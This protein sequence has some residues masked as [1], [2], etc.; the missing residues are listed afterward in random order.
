VAAD[1][2]HV[3][4]VRTVHYERW[5]MEQGLCLTAEGWRRV[6]RLLSRCHVVTEWGR[7]RSE[8]VWWNARPGPDARA[9]RCEIERVVRECGEPD[10]CGCS[11]RRPSIKRG[12]TLT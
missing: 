12:I 6:E 1:P 2:R 7:G 4:G 11:G 5:W 8:G 10:V 3:S 9:L